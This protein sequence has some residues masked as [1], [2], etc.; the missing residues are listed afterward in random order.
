[1]SKQNFVANHN[2][3]G[4]INAAGYANKY[5]DYKKVIS[6][7]SFDADWRPRYPI[8]ILPRMRNRVA[9]ANR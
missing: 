8:V 6:Q 2:Q 7:R 9:F 4:L 1:M 3:E 5:M